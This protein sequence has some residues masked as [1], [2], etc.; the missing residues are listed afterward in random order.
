VT[1]EIDG[2]AKVNGRG[3]FTFKVI[4]VDNADPGRNRDR[5]SL[6][7][8]N[9]YRASGTLKGGNIQIHKDCGK[10]HDDND[11]ENYFDKDENDGHNNCNN[12]RLNEQDLFEKFNDWNN[13]H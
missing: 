10:S 8:S 1:R 3:A 11:R 7:L 6:Q 9:G 12:D 2:I 13:Q 5:F 4:V